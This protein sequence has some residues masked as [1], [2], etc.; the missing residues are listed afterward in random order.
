MTV[1][2]VLGLVAAGLYLLTQDGLSLSAVMTAIRRADPMWLAVAFA[3]AVACY[4]G[5]AV[6]YQALVRVQAGPQVGLWVALRLAVAVFGASVIATAAGRLGVEYWSLRKMREPSAAAWAR[7]IALNTTAWAVL[8]AVTAVAAVVLLAGGR[9]PLALELAWIAALPLCTPAAVYLATRSSPRAASEDGG[10][11]QLLLATVVR[12]LRLVG[13]LAAERARG[14]RAVGGAIVFWAG[15]CLVLWAALRA[16]GVHLGWAQLVVGYTT[17][18]LATM[19]PLPAGGIGGVETAAVFGLTLVGAP[20]GP[21]LLAVLVQRLCTY[22][23]PLAAAMIASGVIR[24]LPRQLAAVPR[25][26]VSRSVALRREAPF[27]AG[28]VRS[29]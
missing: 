14:W 13:S 23:L 18:Y 27:S 19:L 5:Y 2:V 4:P 16:F 26:G 24:R 21:A 11:L 17:G 20:A 7:V 3:G 15:E 28:A 9:A 8:T 10:R 29:G 12:S 25:P 22:W 6:L 1:G